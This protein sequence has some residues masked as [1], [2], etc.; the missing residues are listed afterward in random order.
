[1]YVVVFLLAPFLDRPQFMVLF[2]SWGHWNRDD[3]ESRVFFVRRNFFAKFI[4]Q[5]KPPCLLYVRVPDGGR[6][7]A[8][9]IFIFLGPGGVAVA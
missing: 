2:S 9:F 3:D 1:M 8:L 6:L 4:E 7:V 5:S